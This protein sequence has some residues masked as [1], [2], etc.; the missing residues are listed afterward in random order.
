MKRIISIIVFITVILSLTAC[1]RNAE[2]DTAEKETVPASE[3]IIRSIPFKAQYIRTNGYN[4][5]AEYPKT[6]WIESVQ[7]LKEYYEKNK[8]TYSFRDEF[9]G[10][11]KKYD[12]AFFENH[13]LIFVL[14]EEPSGSISHKVTD[15]SLSPS[16]QN[17]VQYFVQPVFQRTVPEVQTCDMA[18]WHIIIEIS[19][20][21]GSHNSMLQD[22]II[23]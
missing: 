3:T 14:L 22:A 9:D 21:Y 2:T 20:E 12:E 11:I 1:G 16:P 5:G 8:G 10:A 23:N 19:K 17:K 18:E 7:E 13:N 6:L 15:V 4:E